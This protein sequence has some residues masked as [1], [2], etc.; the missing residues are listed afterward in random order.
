MALLFCYD[1]EFVAG[2]LEENEKL[3]RTMT[4]KIILQVGCRINNNF[5]CADKRLL[6]NRA[7][8]SWLLRN[9]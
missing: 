7:E 9:I 6:A 8:A 1:F 5:P 2:L 3:E 4:E